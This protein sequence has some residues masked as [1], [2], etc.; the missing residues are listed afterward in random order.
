[1]QSLRPVR[2]LVSPPASTTHFNLL[3]WLDLVLFKVFADLS[4]CPFAHVLTIVSSSST[5][6]STCCAWYAGWLCAIRALIR[7]CMRRVGGVV[8]WTC[9]V[10]VRCRML[11]I[12]QHNLY[13][14]VVLWPLH[15]AQDVGTEWLLWCYHSIKNDHITNSPRDKICR[16]K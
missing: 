2:S 11:S 8:K 10:L 9:G 4:S 1:M 5:R 7:T 12:S 15:R 14:G 6:C 13:I 3:L 16:V